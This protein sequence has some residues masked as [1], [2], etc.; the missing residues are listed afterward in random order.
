MQG[1]WG[2]N[3]TLSERKGNA[4]S[5]LF[6]SLKALHDS[7]P[8]SCCDLSAI[9]RSALLFALPTSDSLANAVTSSQTTFYMKNQHSFCTHGLQ[10]LSQLCVM[11]IERCSVL[12]AMTAAIGFESAFAITARLCLP[13]LFSS[14]R[15]LFLLD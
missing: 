2:E 7:A 8:L 13:L 6:F 14:S 12:T 1:V 15:S 3:E 4:T 5:F 11:H 10:R 9:E